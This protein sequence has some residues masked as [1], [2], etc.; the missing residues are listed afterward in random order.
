VWLK[1]AATASKE[2]R[3]EFVTQVVFNSYAMT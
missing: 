2:T 3:W 1:L